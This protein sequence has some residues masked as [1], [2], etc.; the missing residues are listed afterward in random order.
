MNN[1][2]Q[3]GRQQ[4]STRARERERER[5]EQTRKKGGGWRGR[6]SREVGSS[7][8]CSNNGDSPAKQRTHN[9]KK[10]PAAPETRDALWEGGVSRPGGFVFVH[11][12]FGCDIRVAIFLLLSCLVSWLDHHHNHYHLAP[13]MAPCASHFRSMACRAGPCNPWLAPNDAMQG[14]SSQSPQSPQ[15]MS[16]HRSKRPWGGGA[17]F[18]YFSDPLSDRLR[19]YGACEVNIDDRGNPG[20]P[21]LEPRVLF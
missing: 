10:A 3:T 14:T 8:K 12:A 9:Q 4:T 11:A 5:R 13:G 7:A 17:S 18:P 20:N 15:C 19:K 1:Q 6:I 16:H 21:V 2:E